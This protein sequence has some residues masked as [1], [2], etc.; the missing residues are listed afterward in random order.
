MKAADPDSPVHPRAVFLARAFLCVAGVLLVA[1]GLAMGFES[2]ASPAWWAP[3]VAVIAGCACLASAVLEKPTGVVA[4]F[5]VFF[6]PW[7]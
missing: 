4:T 1:L 5:L 6:F 3:P 2:L 7:T